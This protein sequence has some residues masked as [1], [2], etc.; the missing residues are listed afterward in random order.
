M[1]A[2]EQPGQLLF[3]PLGFF[4]FFCQLCSFAYGQVGEV[5]FIGVLG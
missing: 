4:I 1:H 5:K 2:N 3:L